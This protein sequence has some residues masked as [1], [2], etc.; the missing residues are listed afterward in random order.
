MPVL[1]RSQ[2]ISAS[3]HTRSRIFQMPAVLQ[4]ALT[5]PRHAAHYGVARDPSRQRNGLLSARMKT[6]R[7]SEV[8][9][10]MHP[11]HDDR[12]DGAVTVRTEDEEGCP[13]IFRS[14][15]RGVEVKEFLNGSRTLLLPPNRDRSNTQD[16]AKFR[17]VGNRQP[18]T[19]LDLDHVK[20]GDNCPHMR[21]RGQDSL[22]LTEERSSTKQ[23]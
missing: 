8:S 2:M 1:W 16:I 12:T 15:N 6:R 23:T 3:R 18:Q 14:H 9:V 19:K 7:I 22:L 21:K 13:E 5:N 11:T 10:P 20:G 17:A 4:T